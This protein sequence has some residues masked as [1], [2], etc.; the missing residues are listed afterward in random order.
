M[1]VCFSNQITSS[2]HQYAAPDKEPLPPPPPRSVT[3]RAPFVTSPLSST[4]STF[5]LSISHLLFIT[6]RLEEGELTSI[7]PS[8]LLKKGFLPPFLSRSPPPRSRCLGL[9]GR[10]SHKNPCDGSQVGG[11]GAVTWKIT[12]K[13]RRGK[14]R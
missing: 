1:H 3:I 9:C 12:Q 5:P 13:G 8:G 7:K 4:F 10:R 6:V 2:P 11:R 14:E